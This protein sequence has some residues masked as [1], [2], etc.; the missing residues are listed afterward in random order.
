MV[1]ITPLP[2]A[3]PIVLGVVDLAGTVVPVIDT[4]KR[5]ALP[6]R[7]LTL[8]DHLVIATTGRRT[9]ALLVDETHGVLEASA[10]SHAAADGILPGLDL[11]DGAITREDGLILIHDLARLLSLDDEA[12]IDRALAPAV[13][14]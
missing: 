10:D 8:S 7:A 14:P 13:N 5:F 2:E 4:R 1:A 9:V 12:A 11:F 6:S 3:P